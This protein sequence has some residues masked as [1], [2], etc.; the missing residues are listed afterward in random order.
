LN[1]REP[2]V[3]RQPGR[4]R[5]FGRPSELVSVTLPTDVVQGLRQ[6]DNDVASAIV[7]L[8]ELAPTLTR[9]STVD[10]ELVFIA[11]RRFLIVVNALA[12]R[13][14]PGVDIIPLDGN[15]AFLALA[16]ER[17]VSD[18]ELAV[19]DRLSSAV[20][21][22]GERERRALE[23]LRRQ[24]RIWHDDPALRFRARAIIVVESSSA[25]RTRRAARARVDDQ[26][27]VELMPFAPG[28]HLILVNSTV[29]R[30]LPGV[31]IIPIGRARSFVAL[32]PGQSASDV[33][34]AVNSRLAKAADRERQALLHLRDQLKM[35]RASSLVF[36][37]RAIIV[38]ESL[39]ASRAKD[40][41]RR[42]LAERKRHNGQRTALHA[43]TPR[44]ELASA[45]KAQPFGA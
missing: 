27:D 12:I 11:D 10:V 17:G 3:H 42:G 41:R 36:R 8:F 16:P 45:T 39:A 31:D 35:W 22:M 32:A 38:V 25:T 28:R 4:P 21:A 18:L 14:L 44:A 40:Q 23:H 6:I 26:P 37:E 13:S 33:E 9:D 43:P 24:L 5:K 29:I 19:V 20:D 34:I 7:R 2:A 30:S 15:R 1:R